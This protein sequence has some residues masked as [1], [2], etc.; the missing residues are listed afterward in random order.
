MVCPKA[1]FNLFCVFILFLVVTKKPKSLF[2]LVLSEED[3]LVSTH[4]DRSD[5]DEGSFLET[6]FGENEAIPYGFDRENDCLFIATGSIEVSDC[7]RKQPIKELFVR[8]I[9]AFK[10]G[11]E[12]TKM[13]QPYGNNS[14]LKDRSFRIDAKAYDEY[15]QVA[16][17]I[18]SDMKSQ[19]RQYIIGKPLFDGWM[20]KSCYRDYKAFIEG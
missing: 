8:N 14:V 6:F 20:D 18:L 9:V 7:T 10:N 12:V 19:G 3:S 5:S 11:T 4:H 15:T 17:I 13:T 2:D 1:L 16:L